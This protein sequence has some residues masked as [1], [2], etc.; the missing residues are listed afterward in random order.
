MDP[1]E[2][3]VLISQLPGEILDFVVSPVDKG[4]IEPTD[5][6]LEAIEQELEGGL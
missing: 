6:E 2:E 5:E 1:A 4:V 3:T